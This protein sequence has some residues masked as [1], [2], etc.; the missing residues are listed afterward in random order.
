MKK[1]YFGKLVAIAMIFAGF[2]LTGC[3]ENDNPSSVKQWIKPEVQLVDGGA[4]ITGSSTADINR[5][6]GR[7]KQEIYNAAQSGDQFTIDIQTPVLNSVEGDNTLNIATLTG[8]DL[9]LNLPSNIV[10]DVPL[11]IQTTGVAD[12]A[13]AAASDNQ[14]EIN[15]PSGGSN[16]DL[17]INMPT[18]TV[19]LKGGNI[20]DLVATTAFNTLVIEDGVTINW[21]KMKDGRA[22]VKDGGKVLGYLRDGD[23]EEYNN[24][25]A[26]AGKDGFEPRGTFYGPDVYY[27]KDE[28]EERYFT[29]NLKIVKGKAAKAIV[30][31]QNAEA[32]DALES[33]IIADGAAAAIGIHDNYWDSEKA[34]WVD[35]P[36]KGVKLIEGLGNK[37]AK[38]YPSDIDP[39]WQDEDKNPVNQSNMNF[40]HVKE[41]KNVV[42][43][44]TIY[45]EYY[46]VTT[47]E[48]EDY[49]CEIGN[50]NSIPNS[51]DCDFISP[52]VIYGNVENGV[53]PTLTNCTL[54]CSPGS[55]SYYNTQWGYYGWYSSE[56]VNINVINSKLTADGIYAMSPNCEGSTF[57]GNDISFTNY[58]VSGNTATVKNCKFETSEKNANASITFPYQTKD[59]SSFNFGFDTCEFGK[60]FKFFTDYE[61]EEPWLDKDGKPVTKGYYWY[62]LEED[63]TT[64]KR[65]ERGNAIR[66]QSADEKDIPEANKANYEGGSTWWGSNGYWIDEN[67]NGLKLP[68]YYKDYKGYLTLKSSTL[69]GKAITSKTDMIAGVNQGKDEKGE[70]ATRTY[71]II[72]GT[73]YEALYNANDDKWILVAVE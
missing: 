62:E 11:I 23:E 55:G 44:A 26:R 54:T 71:Y 39:N 65:D 53:M 59:R 40:N 60:G 50:I 16:I 8:G 28:A 35:A 52:S 24:E 3:N 48:Y 51:T 42:A 34:T 13:P 61:G 1:N 56:I 12:D 6:L 4:I 10:T 46:D 63:G 15:F 43:D 36:A 45:P 41:L 7:V 67:P 5:M 72:D 29:Q 14:V 19:T 17:A 66:H 70:Q 33:I 68:T 47:D 27:I 38:I 37:T 58:F 20:D 2:T 30:G 69:D 73:T 32:K 49:T 18:T 25:D 31:I 57:K 21:L 64:I 9:V 22:L